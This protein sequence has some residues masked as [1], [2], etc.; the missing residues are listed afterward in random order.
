MVHFQR[1]ISALLGDQKSN[2]SYVHQGVNAIL[3]NVDS[4]NLKDV[5][6]GVLEMN[7][8]LD[9]CWNGFE[10]VVSDIVR[11]GSGEC[12]SIPGVSIVSIQK[13]DDT[14]PPSSLYQSVLTEC[15]PSTNH[16]DVGLENAGRTWKNIDESMDDDMEDNVEDSSNELVDGNNRLQY[17]L[18]SNCQDDQ[19][20]SMSQGQSSSS[21]CLIPESDGCDKYVGLSSFSE[22]SNYTP[23]EKFSP[24]FAGDFEPN[25]HSEHLKRASM[26]LEGDA[27]CSANMLE[28]V[29]PQISNRSDY[30]GNMNSSNV[31]PLNTNRCSC[32]HQCGL[33]NTYL[34]SP[35][36]PMPFKN[37]PT[38]GIAN[39]NYSN[40][41]AS[42]VFRPLTTS[43]VQSTS[44]QSMLHND[45]MSKSLS[46]VMY[47]IAV[48]PSSAEKSNLVE[49]GVPNYM[50]D[51]VYAVPVM[52]SSTASNFGRAD[53]HNG[54]FNVNESRLD[55]V[56]YE[57]ARQL[58]YLSQI[59]GSETPP[60]YSPYVV[61]CTGSLPVEG[62]MQTSAAQNM[63]L[64]VYSVT[65]SRQPIFYP[66][67]L[68]NKVQR[69]SN[70]NSVIGL[71]GNQP[72]NDNLLPISM[73][74]RRQNESAQLILLTPN[75]DDGCK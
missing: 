56:H 60:G 11:D 20:G 50:S 30:S 48:Q 4:C 28:N 66:S 52:P 42:P 25:L 69:P 55:G 62:C 40:V 75:S 14:T 54:L 21:P 7:N 9:H 57:S 16:L 72:G 29:Q 53:I 26:V 22:L 18:P 5:K 65:D 58:S 32:T 17:I 70:V 63:S 71:S 45:E 23:L 15:N 1:S 6:I 13:K 41:A 12:V 73:Q 37:N 44:G 3:A 51:V 19:Q 33:Q 68:E 49:S 27:D 34:S 74:D 10:E 43:S 31:L 24:Q 2:G 36:L 8:L 47:A 67:L 59:L 61:F 39:K 64:Q 38:D 35:L 46:N